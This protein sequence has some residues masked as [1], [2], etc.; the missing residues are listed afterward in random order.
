MSYEEQATKTW[1]LLVAALAFLV[2][3]YIGISFPRYTRNR[4][5]TEYNRAIVQ[6]DTIVPSV[7]KLVGNYFVLVTEKGED[8]RYQG[9]VLEDALGQLILRIYDEYEPRTIH[10]GIDGETVTSDELGVGIMT[11]KK[12]IDKTTITFTKA[13]SICILT[14]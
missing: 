1:P 4:L 6:E 7:S 9:S 3:L 8:T 5:R 10:L 14:K 11:Y 2:L 12:N 13:N